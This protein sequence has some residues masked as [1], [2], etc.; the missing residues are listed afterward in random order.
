MSAIE[1]GNYFTVVSSIDAGADVNSVTGPTRW[2]TRIKDPDKRVWATGDHPINMALSTGMPPL[3]FSAAHASESNNDIV[4]HLLDNGADPNQNLRYENFFYRWYSPAMLEALQD[5]ALRNSIDFCENYVHGFSVVHALV[6]WGGSVETLSK[7]ID[8]GASFTEE[9]CVGMQPLH[10][11]IMTGNVDLL[12][13]LLQRGASAN[14]PGPVFYEDV[15]F[16][17]R[18][19]PLFMACMGSNFFVISP[20]TQTSMVE[21]LIDFGANVGATIITEMTSQVQTHVRAY[22][23]SLPGYGPERF[24]DD[25]RRGESWHVLM[26]AAYYGMPADAVRLL[27]QNGA[28]PYGQVSDGFRPLCL[29]LGKES[30]DVAEAIIESS[31]DPAMQLDDLCHADVL[32]RPIV[33]EDACPLW[34]IAAGGIS[35]SD[36]MRA[37]R[38]HLAEALINQ[39]ADIHCQSEA[40]TWHDTLSEPSVGDSRALH[41]AV[42]YGFPEMVEMLINRGALG[43]AKHSHS[44]II[45]ASGES[46]LTAHWKELLTRS[47]DLVDE[48]QNRRG[49]YGG[50]IARCKDVIVFPIYKSDVINVYP[51]PR[52]SCKILHV[53]VNLLPSCRRYVASVLEK[54]TCIP[55]RIIVCSLTY[56]RVII[57]ILY[58][59][60]R[61]N[62]ARS[63]A[64]AT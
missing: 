55:A 40:N 7:L 14:A 58:I 51:T 41:V 31:N 6:A 5:T 48:F 44:V 62:F 57:S 36:E 34:M 39:G 15:V 52:C 24:V 22:H 43:A 16:G 29:A 8:G 3:F 53:N 23:R 37:K 35:H 12:T 21:L 2:P 64:A 19:S 18:V 56:Y 13:V 49:R 25:W 42:A 30:W 60:S 4:Q 1:S 45:G 28:N 59:K 10:W 50:R 9:S 17:S 33:F 38:I 26:L 11:A 46:E 54:S 61:A 27:L 63:S 47:L 20:D 32:D